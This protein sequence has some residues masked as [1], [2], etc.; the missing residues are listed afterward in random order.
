MSQINDAELR[1]RAVEFSKRYA[2]ITKE[3]AEAQTFWN[4]FFLVFGIDRQKVAEFEKS[5]KKLSGTTGRIDLFWRGKLIAEHKSK[6]EDLSD[7]ITQLQQYFFG[8][9]EDDKPR[10]LIV[11]D[12]HKIK[13]YDTKNFNS[14]KKQSQFQ[15]TL[16]EFP[17]NLHKFSFITG[18]KSSWEDE[19]A[20]NIK[21][22]KLMGKLHDALKANGYKGTNLEKYLMRLLFCLFAED[23]G[24]FPKGL[25]KTYILEHTKEDGS[26]TGSQLNSLF[27][28][29]N[30]PT[31]K[32][33]KNIPD[34]LK[35]FD[36]VNG[37]MYAEQLPVAHF[38]KTQ[39]DI[40][41]ECCS[42]NWNDISPVIFGSMFQY[43]MDE[44]KRENVGAHYTSE[45]NIMKAIK[46]LFLDELEKE[47]EKVKH[48]KP[49]LTSFQKKIEKLKFLDPAC[50]CGNF[51]IIA[52]RELRKL[53]IDILKQL[54]IIDKK[55][56]NNQ[57]ALRA[58][59]SFV[60]LDSFYG[61]E[62]EE[63]PAKVAETAMWLMEHKMNQKMTEECGEYVATLPLKKSATIIHG[64]ALR[65]N[66]SEIIPNSFLSYIIGNPPFI[67]NKKRN[68]EQKKDMVVIC[69]NSDNSGILDYVCAWYIK[70]AN[71][72]KGTQ[73]KVAFVSTNSITQGEQA[74][75]LW[76][77]L[78]K[79]EIKIHFAHRTFKWSNEAKGNAGVY[80]VIIGFANY[81]INDKYIYEYDTP[82]SPKAHKRK[83]KNIN[84]YLIDFED[85]I[86]SS[87][88]KPICNVLKMSRGNSPY[89]GG[90][91]L[92]TNEEKIEFL[93][94]EPNAKK[95][96]KPL[97]SS[98]EY[99]AGEKRWCLWLVNA[100]PKEIK[101]MPLVTQRIKKVFDFRSD[102][103]RGEETKKYASTPSL[104]RDKKTPKSF[105]IIPRH[106][107]EN[108]KYI[109]M[110]FFGKES[111]PSDS[112]MIIPNGSLYDFGILMSEMHMAWMRQVCGRLE[113]RFRY[114]SDIVYNNFPFP[115]NVSAKAK[116]NV[117]QKVQ[118]ILDIRKKY[119]D[120]SP[121]DLY[122][123]P[124]TAV[125]LVKAHEELDKAVD[126]CYSLKFKEESKRLQFLFNLYKEKTTVPE[127]F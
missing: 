54:H 32:R 120:S 55:I 11:T 47:F 116:V 67:S 43:V 3:N 111:I 110:G 41:L 35:R 5:V 63:F 21:A 25:F 15:I 22:T 122:D 127:L 119:S 124:M 45:K 8:I 87:R 66:W 18:N 103:K 64:N 82:N 16:A 91:L 12:F 79:S 104:F 74:S 19:E 83:A 51:L 58:L 1:L 107:S 46:G 99:L 112:C 56:D 90:N 57:T 85:I 126:L 13:V 93:K 94:E 108:R 73:I 17:D 49:L 31:N 52:Y 77:Y 61:I 70:A 48:S 118:K 115:D 6:G 101:K 26:N 71:Y 81:N 2:N 62:H 109:P 95:F 24:I 102:D 53:E 69:K 9:S 34:I 14:E 75:V 100:D 98:D 40:L 30:I 65:L 117:E 20:V 28:I 88:S 39:R 72:I 37:S 106:S 60:H 105:I 92:F 59:Q 4:H 76:E 38:N 78:K 7:A 44:K 121:S 36:Y 114:S 68:P 10:Y 86:I 89:D 42:F 29:L 23:T 113:S 84:L 96:I 125:D 123:M 50:G 80:C 27:E 97:I 33:Q